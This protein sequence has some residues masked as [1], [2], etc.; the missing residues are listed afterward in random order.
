MMTV[1]ASFADERQQSVAVGQLHPVVFEH[2]ALA[3]VVMH[4][5]AVDPRLPRHVVV[6]L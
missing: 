4:A 1:F 2:R 5:V 3:A 6:V